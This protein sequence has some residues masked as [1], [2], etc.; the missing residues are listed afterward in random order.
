M[1]S[2]PSTIR[3]P[4]NERLVCN[5]EQLSH[6]T[7][8]RSKWATTFPDPD[9]DSHALRI[10]IW[11]LMQVLV[12]KSS[13]VLIG[14]I[15]VLAELTE[16]KRVVPSSQ[17]NS[18]IKHFL[19]ATLKECVG[20][21]SQIIKIR[22]KYYSILAYKFSCALHH[23]FSRRWFPIR[24]PAWLNIVTNTTDSYGWTAVHNPLWRTND[25][26]Y[27][28]IS[29]CISSLANWKLW[30]QVCELSLYHDWDYHQTKKM[31]SEVVYNLISHLSTQHQSDTS[32]NASFILRYDIKKTAQ[33]CEYFEGRKGG[34]C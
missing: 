6:H 2:P 1:K 31:L 8:S 4:P 11:I 29:G 18:D 9:K 16:S 5:L 7:F 13:Y 14:W 32:T 30:T 34:K 22:L 19:S 26:T 3:V 15:N 25:G 12:L 24:W 10:W 33:W 27:E 20:K 21:T 17:A 23:P 28:S